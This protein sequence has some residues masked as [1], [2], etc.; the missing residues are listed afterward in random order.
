M[1][2]L[3]TS[4]DPRPPSEETPQGR[5]LTR[6]DCAAQVAGIKRGIAFA[7]LLATTSIA[8]AYIPTVLGESRWGDVVVNAVQVR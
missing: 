5:G 7:L 3:L 2:L 4:H 6:V 8:S 1:F